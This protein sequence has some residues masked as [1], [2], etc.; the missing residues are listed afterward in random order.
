MLSLVPSEPCTLEVASVTS[1]SVTLQWMPPETP[2]GVITHYSIQFDGTVVDNFHKK[3]LTKMMRTVEGLSP[4]TEYLVQLR[5]H[6]RV[7]AGPPASLTVKTG[8]FLIPQCF[9]LILL[10]SILCFLTSYNSVL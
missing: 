1:S 8:K 7:A 2:N 9:I 3:T 10:S 6:T 5:A 4:D